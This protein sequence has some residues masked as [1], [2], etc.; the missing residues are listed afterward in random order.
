VIDERDS[1]AI[2]AGFGR[3]G[4]T[5]SR[6]LQAQGFKTT[7]LDHDASQVDMLRQFGFKVFYGDASRPDLLEAA[8]A[9][10]AKILVVAVDDQEK[11]L[12]IVQT[13]Q[14]HFPHLTLFARA[15][16]RV[17]AYELINAGVKHVYREVFGS[18]LELAEDA[19][20]ALGVHRYTASRAAR[21]FRHVDQ[22]AL[23]RVA[24]HVGDT[25]A[26]IDASRA[27]RDEVTRVLA[28]DRQAQLDDHAWEAPDKRPDVE[29]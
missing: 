11:I 26:L 18:S 23:Y 13:A 1:P 21:T 7:V 28:N 12:E 16:D 19:L 29:D 5:V 3:F 2:I 10:D 17:H 22:K 6:L 25:A 20:A 8:G 24:P 14:R 27:A 9:R 15:W 4:M